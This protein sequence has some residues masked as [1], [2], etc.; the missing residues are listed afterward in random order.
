MGVDAERRPHPVEQ[1]TAQ[2][3]AAGEDAAQF[4]TVVP[5]AGEPHQFRAV[6]GRNTLRILYSAIIC[7]AA[8]GSNFR[9]RWPTIGTP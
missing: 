7:I 3:F 6:G 5:D 8:C 2:R 1:F 9:A 4:D